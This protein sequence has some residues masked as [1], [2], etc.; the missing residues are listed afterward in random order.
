MFADTNISPTNPPMLSGSPCPPASAGPA[1][2]I[3]APHADPV[4][5]LVGGRDHVLGEARGALEHPVDQLGVEVLAAEVAVM[6]LGAQDLLE[7]VA[8]LA[9]R[10]LVGGHATRRVSRPLRRS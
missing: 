2:V 10:D 4:A 1:A 7:D 5:G 6:G 9:Q 8:E 3:L